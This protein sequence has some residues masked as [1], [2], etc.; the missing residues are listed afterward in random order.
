M[1][2]YGISPKREVHTLPAFEI[3]L[4]C[5]CHVQ[6]FLLHVNIQVDIVSVSTTVFLG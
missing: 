2:D 3:N 4:G 1:V 6:R 5:R